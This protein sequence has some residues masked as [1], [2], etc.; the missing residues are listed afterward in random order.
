MNIGTAIGTACVEVARTPPRK[1]KIL[2]ARVIMAAQIL[3]L[4]SAFFPPLGYILIATTTN[5]TTNIVVN[6]HPKMRRRERKIK[7]E[8]HAILRF[9]YRI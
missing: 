8:N 4:M 5:K 3:N 1:R 7:K 6:S 2:G 9:L